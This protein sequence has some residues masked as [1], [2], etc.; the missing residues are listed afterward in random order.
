MGYNNYIEEFKALMKK[1]EEEYPNE[2]EL[3][4]L[5]QSGTSG[6]A[7]AF[8]K[9]IER[10]QYW[11]AQCAVKFYFSSLDFEELFSFALE[12]L[13]KSIYSYDIESGTPFAIYAQKAMNQKILEGINSVGNPR[14]RLTLT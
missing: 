10:N 7:R 2:Q 8:D 6:S 11:A 13:W 4:A 1:C 9:I 5:A 14:G 12:G 3:I